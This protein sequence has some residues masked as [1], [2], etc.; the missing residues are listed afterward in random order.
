MCSRQQLTC[1]VG[2]TCGGPI[3][4]KWEK[5]VRSKGQ[6]VKKDK[7]SKWAKGPAVVTGRKTEILGRVR[8]DREMAWFEGSQERGF[9][10]A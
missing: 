7:G 6:R 9:R 8:I 2:W 1:G 10:R 5:G 4:G 3:F